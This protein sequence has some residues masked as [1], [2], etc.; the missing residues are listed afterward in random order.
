[1]TPQDIKKYFFTYRDGLTADVLRRGGVPCKM[2]FG[3]QIPQIAALAREMSDMP[4][5]EKDSLGRILWNDRSVRES[6]LLACYLLN[7][8]SVMME[9]ALHMAADVQSQEEADI[10][11]FR[12]LR[13]LPYASELLDRLDSESPVAR[14]LA[15]MIC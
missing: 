2:I 13:H 7:P 3:L 15:R 10:L 12:L 11:V 14:A 8:E 4:A 1:M 6:R 5:A 9:E